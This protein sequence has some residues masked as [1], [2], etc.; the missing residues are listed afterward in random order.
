MHA[1]GAAAW[2][3]TLMQDQQLAGVIMWIPAGMVYLAAV[4]WVFVRW[5]R[6]AERRAAPPLRRTPLLMPAVAAALIALAAGPAQ[7]QS[8]A[9]GQ[10]P[11]F[12]GDP[13]RGARLITDY[14]CGACHTIPG[15]AGAD[16]IVGPPLTLIGRR[17]YV[18]GMLRNTPDNLMMWLRDPQRIVPGN[19]MPDMGITPKDARDIAAYLYTLR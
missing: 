12:G 3:L 7:A 16:G 4:Q 17:I 13:D 2:G 15:I 5:L 14:G 10:P 9:Q 1:A 8:P 11:N 18:A 6:D 19:A